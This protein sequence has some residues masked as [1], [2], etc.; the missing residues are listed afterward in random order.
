MVIMKPTLVVLITVVSVAIAQ[1]PSYAGRSPIGYPAVETT[2]LAEVLG[3]RFG[4]DNTPTTTVRLPIEA[5][6]D[7]DLVARLRKFPV[8]KQPFWLINWIALEE[9]RKNPQT[10]PQKPNV[11]INKSVQVSQP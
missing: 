3:N 2:T 5:Q 7:A 9:Y 6:G 11:F 8:D 10:Y 1:R 4:D